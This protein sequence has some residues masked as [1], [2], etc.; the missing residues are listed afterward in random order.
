VPLYEYRC[1]QCSEKFERLVRM[2]DAEG[3]IA[4]PKC[5]AVETKRLVSAFG[6]IGSNA[7]TASGESCPQPSFGGG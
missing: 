6:F 3:Q 7:S 2:V 1:S 5:G 4:C